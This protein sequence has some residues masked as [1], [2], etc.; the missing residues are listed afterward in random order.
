VRIVVAMSGGVDSSVAAA[1]LV[2]E[3]HEVIGVHLRLHDEGTSA[4]PTARQKTCCGLD[5]AEDAR[6][7]ADALGI[8]FYVWNLRDAFKKAVIDGFVGDW[9]AGRTP[10]PCIHCNGVLKFRVLLARTRALGADK[11]ATGHYAR[12]APRDGQA[13]LRTAVDPAKDQSYFLFPMTPE[14]LSATA[15]PLGGLSKPEVRAEAARL[16][17]VTAAKPESQ[18]VCF[19]PD[20][21]RAGFVARQRPDLDGS[22]DIVLEDGRV[23]GRHEG[24]WRYT[25][26]QRRGLG[27]SIGPDPLY[28]LRVEP[29]TRR[30]V[31]GPDR[32][33]AHTGL[34]AHSCTWTHPPD[35]SQTV[36][37]R[38]RHLGDL[39]A[40]TIRPVDGDDTVQVDLH[41]PVRAITPGQAAVC[42][43]AGGHVLGG[44]WIRRAVEAA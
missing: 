11:L 34:V 16:G 39:T 38:T 15:F 18:D 29:D 27:V 42:Y 1:Q 8:P 31:V 28:V 13:T 4:V 26:G 9:I 20:G 40:A 44:G 33:L 7:V 41:E 43:D 37:V 36:W 10:N 30:V 24:Y 32:R 22:G 5:D 12:I 35:P 6:R 17:L 2:E 21:D 14:A 19:L 23:L 25:V 3:G